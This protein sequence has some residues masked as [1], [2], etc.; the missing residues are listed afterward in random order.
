MSQ[1]PRANAIRKRRARKRLAGTNKEIVQR[2]RT[3]KYHLD[4]ARYYLSVGASQQE[5]NASYGSL[6]WERRKLERP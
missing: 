2:K 6:M 4:C 5:F 1:N 3:M